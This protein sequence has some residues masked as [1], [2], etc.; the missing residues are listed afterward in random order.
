[1]MRFSLTFVALIVGLFVSTTT[2]IAVDPDEDVKARQGILQNMGKEMKTL[3]GIAKG[4][5]ESQHKEL[6]AS[7][8]AMRA[9][10][11][12]PWPYFT[13]ETAVARINHKAKSTIWSD[14]AGFR[15]AQEQFINAANALA[16]TAATGKPDD[17]RAKI[18]A[19]G[20]ACG[21][22]HKAFKD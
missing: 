5:V 12:Q 9:L 21:A 3:G 8:T 7:T 1:M 14:P 10:A 15:T 11:P 6:V 2:V 4:D 16:L 13:Q 17:V 18:D 19:L 20:A 22:C